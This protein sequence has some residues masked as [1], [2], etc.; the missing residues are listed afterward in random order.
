MNNVFNI[1]YKNIP[2]YL[3]GLNMRIFTDK[4]NTFLAKLPFLI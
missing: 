2:E 3:R 1:I 4:R